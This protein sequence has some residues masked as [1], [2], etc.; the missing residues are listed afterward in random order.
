MKSTILTSAFAL[1]AAVLGFQT[2]AL[3]DPSSFSIKSIQYAGTGCPA[4]TVAG[5]VSPDLKAFTLLFDGYVAEAG[6]GVSLAASR[7]N[8]QLSISFTCPAGYQFALVD[9]DTRGFYSLDPFVT[10]TQK[11]SF[12]FQ[13]SAVTPS[14]ERVVTGS[15]DGDY[16]ARDTFPAAQ[17]V[18]GACGA[19]SRALNINTQVRVD[20]SRAR[21]NRGII[22]VDSLDGSLR[23]TF[24]ITW[25]RS[26][27]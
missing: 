27:L 1:A 21:N 17:R 9:V 6:P 15:A 14:V 4:G 26:A 7:K 8:C 2:P 13:G 11:T 10:A 18:W 16:Q 3:A 20:N 12:Y 24:G 19:S 22:T 23:E 25:Q 5:N